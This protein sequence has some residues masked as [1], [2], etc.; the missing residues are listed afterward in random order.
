[1]SRPTTLLRPGSGLLAACLIA[2]ALAAGC[3]RE[4]EGQAGR[5]TAPPVPETFV[6]DPTTMAW[7]GPIEKAHGRETWRSKPALAADITVELGGRVANQG[8]LVFKTDLSA[9][10][11]EL[12]DGTVLVFDG[13]DAWVSPSVSDFQ[14]ARWHLRAWP[15]LMAL[16]AKLRDHGTR[17]EPMGQRDL[18]GKTYDVA[19]LTFEP[20]TGDTPDDWYL[21]H[22]DPEND[23][24]AAAAFISTYGA[25]VLEAEQAPQAVVYEEFTEVEGVPLPTRLTLWGWNRESGLQ[26]EQPTVE[27]T[28]SNPAFITPEPDTFT[29]PADSVPQPITY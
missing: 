19:R 26:G 18:R 13:Q 20:G 7:T 9:S 29:R 23:R 25:S 10:R 24:L 17:L 16:P 28:F 4:P 27:V 5:E 2:G 22:R 11:I 14:R 6:E 1:M 15:Y 3:Q 8:R 21:I 12:A